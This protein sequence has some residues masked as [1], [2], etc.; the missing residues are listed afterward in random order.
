MTT[1]AP[2]S[3]LDVISELLIE[4]F[5]IPS[6]EVRA[7][8]PMRDLLTD[9]LMV[10]EMA[11]AVHEV[12]GVKVEEEELREATLADLVGSVEARRTDR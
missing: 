7:E 10:V 11:I 6:D 1:S 12:L 9:S 2:E 8:V 3:V 4:R 5:E